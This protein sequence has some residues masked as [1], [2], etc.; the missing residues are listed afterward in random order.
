M[1]TVSDP[2]VSDRERGTGSGQ[3]SQQPVRTEEPP[4]SPSPPP[5]S[6]IEIF[7]KTM[8]RLSCL[9]KG[10]SWPRRHCEVPLCPPDPH[11]HAQHPCPHSSGKAA[12]GL[13]RRGW[14]GREGGC[15]AEPTTL[16]SSLTDSLIFPTKRA[17]FCFQSPY[18]Q[19]GT[20]Y[21]KSVRKTYTS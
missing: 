9:P 1:V 10:G 11:L 19:H 14:G 15:R 3:M 21:L 7:Y 6:C 20:L 4:L 13:R 16:H 17:R 12:P 8:M 5:Q 2:T 18:K